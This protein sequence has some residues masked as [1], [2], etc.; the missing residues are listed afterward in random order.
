MKIALITPPYPLEEYPSPPLGI[1]YVAAI[2]EEMGW[3]VEI[4]DFIVQQLSKK[5]LQGFMESFD[6]DVVG[7]TSVTMNFMSAQRIL[8]EVKNI[9]PGTITLMGGP[10]VSFDVENTLKHYP[11]IDVLVVGEGEETLKEFLPH[12]HT[13]SKWKYIPGLAFRV[14]SEIVMTP[15]RPLIS[16]LSSLPLPARHLLPLTRYLALGF[17][18]S[19]TTSRGCPNQCIFCQGRRLVGSRPRY[20][21][22]DSVIEEIQYLLSLGFF[23]IN[24]ADD[25]FTCRRDRVLEICDKI[26]DRGLDF[27]W[28]AFARVDSVDLDLL[29]AMVN[30]GCDTISFGVE[31]GNEDMLRR[32]KKRIKISQVIEA[33]RLCKKVGMRCLV[34]FIVGLPGENK[35]TLEDTR[36]LAHILEDIGIEYG[37][38]FLAPFPGTTIREK[39]E[40]YDLE[41]L[42]NDWDLYDANRAIVATSHLSPEDMETFVREYERDIEKLNREMEEKYRLGQCSPTERFDFEGRRRTNIIFELLRKDLI[43]NKII[44]RGRYEKE[45]IEVL[46]SY[47]SPFFPKEGYFVKEVLKDLYKKGFLG[48]I[49]E[50]EELRWFWRDNE[51]YIHTIGTNLS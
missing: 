32:I 51:D 46:Y 9:N 34:S 24:F 41:I 42:T 7:A 40:E 36:K 43:R 2:C 19:L 31:S 35:N 33:A 10:H 28:S 29:E 50:G 5:K 16:D 48:Y 8:Y 23:R 45:P 26:V 22:G 27:R 4:W 47:L 49:K 1:C 14:G 21:P 30:A 39:I 18:V 11:H 25:F 20:R 12:A 37:Y 44:I 38:H 13:P 6:P 3:E 17:P 15:K